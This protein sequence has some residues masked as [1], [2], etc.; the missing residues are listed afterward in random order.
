MKTA[1]ITGATSGIGMAMA[2]CLHRKGWQLVLTGRNEDILKRMAK[3]FGTGTKY[4]ALD[5]AQRD[6]AER[7]YDFCQGIK[8]DFLINNAGFGVFGEFTETDLDQ[9]LELIDVNIRAVHI[10]TKLFLKDFV[11]RDSGMIL[12]VASSAGFLSGPL[13]SSYYASKNYVVRLT[14]AIRE[15]LR[16]KGSHV[17]IGVLCPGP[18]DTNF[19]HRAGVTFSV[20]PMPPKYIAEY[21][22]EGSFAGKGV[23]IPTLFM[24]L[25][26]LA[27]RFVPEEFANL[28]IYELQK[29]KE[30]T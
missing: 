25:G 2:I 13:L 29:R 20:K 4:I 14:T 27:S 16:R 21:A 22:I 15:E 6:S 12:N 26:I 18:V 7:I 23:M 1:L 28:F 8:I 30:L 19:N 3:K 17:Q 10:L 24:K 5:L 9:E 11:K